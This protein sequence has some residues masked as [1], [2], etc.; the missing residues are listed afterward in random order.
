MIEMGG[1]Q[2]KEGIMFLN[3]A[4]TCRLILKITVRSVL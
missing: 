3:F 1:S 2:V 4:E